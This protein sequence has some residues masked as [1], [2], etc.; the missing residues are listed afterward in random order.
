[1]AE[2]LSIEV[3]M[4]KR[5]IV[6]YLIQNLEHSSLEL[7]CLS[8]NFLKKLSVFKENKNEMLSVLPF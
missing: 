4:V 6:R 8:I 2:D 3:K 1:M 5:D 7:Q